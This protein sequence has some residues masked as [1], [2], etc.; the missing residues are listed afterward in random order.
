MEVLERTEEWSKLVWIWA[1]DFDLLGSV[2]GG[3]SGANS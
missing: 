3:L 2:I 1:W